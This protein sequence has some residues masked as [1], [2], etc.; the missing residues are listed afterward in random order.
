MRAVIATIAPILVVLLFV[1]VIDIVLQ[2][3]FSRTV[4]NLRTA[5]QMEFT[6]DTGRIN[7]I[8]MLLLFLGFMFTSIHRLLAETLVT[9]QPV[10][11]ERELSNSSFH[12]TLFFALSV[13]LVSKLE[14]K[15]PKSKS[16]RRKASAPRQASGG[17]VLPLMPG[18]EVGEQKKE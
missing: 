15:P 16:T 10:T 2:H 5:I 8:A 3:S 18:T 12:L 14:S 7:F 1:V 6:T 4:N 11:P 9:G 13:L 17:R